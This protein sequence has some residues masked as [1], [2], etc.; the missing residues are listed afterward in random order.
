MLSNR[1]ARL[2]PPPRPVP[3]PLVC[4]AM[5]GLTGGIGAAF[6]IM[7]LGAVWL[8]LG[9]PGVPP[10][11]WVVLFVFVL[12]GAVFFTLSTVRGLRWVALLRYGEVAG[13]ETIQRHSTNTYVNDQPVYRYDY[14]FRGS[15]GRMHAGSSRALGQ[16]E[17]GD[18]AQ[19]PVLYLPSNPERS[20]LVDALPL[21]CPLDVDEEGHWVSYESVWPIVWCGLAWGGVAAMVGYGLLRLLGLV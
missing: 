8:S 16:E 14:R 20:G 17:I 5:L 4:S 1:I 10:W 18:E 15:D 11:V 2:A 12:I 9:D 3:L 6:L 13:A 21:R 19:E 7:G